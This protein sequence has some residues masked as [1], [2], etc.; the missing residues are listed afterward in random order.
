MFSYQKTLNPQKHT[1]E[2]DETDFLHSVEKK[3]IKV[4]FFLNGTEKKD[5]HL[6]SHKM[7][8]FEAFEGISRNIEF[9]ISCQFFKTNMI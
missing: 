9:S 8:T 5:Q 2:P 4:E 1:L 7:E 3:S 6:F